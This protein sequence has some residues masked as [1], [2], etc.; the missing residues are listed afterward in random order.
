MIWKA[1]F[2]VWGEIDVDGVV[3]ESMGWNGGGT[4]SS[5][6]CLGRCAGVTNQSMRVCSGTWHHGGSFF[7][8]ACLFFCRRRHQNRR[9]FV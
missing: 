5:S 8:V 7:L 6:V 4:I 2:D 3:I 1:W 9:R